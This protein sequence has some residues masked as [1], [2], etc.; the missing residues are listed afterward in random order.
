MKGVKQL[1]KNTKAIKIG[2]FAAV[3]V[4]AIV[5]TMIEPFAG[6]EKTGMVFLGIF[7]WWVVMMVLELIPTH[8]STIAALVLAVA[9]GCGTTADAFGSFSGT[10]VWLLIGAF[11]L[12]TALSNSG[13]L[14][15]LAVNIMRLFPGTYTGQLLG[16]S[17]ASLICAPCVPSTTA[18]CTI[19][20]PLAGTVGDKMGYE[21]HSKGA[22]GFFNVVNVITNFGGCMFLTGG[23]VVAVI[24][25]MV[26]DTFTWFG[27]LKIFLVWGIIMVVLT[28]LVSI[29]LYKPGKGEGKTLSKEELSALVKELGPMSKKELCALIILVL[30]IAA[31]MTESIHGIPTYAVALAA[32]ILM[33][34]CGLFSGMDFMTKILWPIVVLVGGILGII[35]L[36]GTTGV[37]A[38]ISG[39]VAPV[40]TP[41]A[42]TPVLL[43][44]ILC[45]VVTLLM[46]AMV[47][48]PAQAAVF[49]TLLSGT[50]INPVIIAFVV[51][52]SAQVFVMP[53]QLATVISAEGVSNGR[54]AHK[55]IVPTAWAY[56]VINIIAVVASVPWWSMLGLIG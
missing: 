41:F 11:G 18:K 17:L 21:P 1:K 39:L 38:W 20:V 24:I 43:L 8:M 37:G 30:T 19:L 33:T 25:A 50:A 55:D 6:L 34:A 14:N 26:T 56:I 13:L 46:F 52:L 2:V 22:I 31:W 51:M 3:T 23:V 35:T 54:I 4:L 27:W 15:R 40:V 16:L 45:V 5:L 36:L 28:V 12:A 10:T 29:I 53:F 32:W 44:A 42:N 48:G 47:Q 9:T 7:I 49:I